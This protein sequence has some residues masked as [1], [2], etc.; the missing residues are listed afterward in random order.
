MRGTELADAIR[1]RQLDAL[2]LYFNPYSDTPFSGRRRLREREAF[3]QK[4]VT[5]RELLEAVSCCSSRI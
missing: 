2:V 4:P 1:A 3:I 5:K